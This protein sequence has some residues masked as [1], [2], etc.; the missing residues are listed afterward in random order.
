MKLELEKAFEEKL[1]AKLRAKPGKPFVD[2]FDTGLVLR[3]YSSGR[4]VAGVRY[5]A[6]GKQRFK[7]IRDVVKGVK[8]VTAA[9]KDAGDIRAKARLG[10]DQVAVDRA[11]RAAIAD[12]GMT[13][14]KLLPAFLAA[15]EANWRKSYRDTVELH[16]TDH[17][18]VLMFKPVKGVTQDDVADALKEVATKRGKVAAARA[19]ASLSTFYAWATHPDQ[20]HAR[21]S[22]VVRVRKRGGDGNGSRLPHLDAERA[23]GSMARAQG[24]E[25][26]LRP[27]RAAAD[28]H[29]AAPKCRDAPVD[30][31][32]PR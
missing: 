18:R 16:L 15:N 3:W 22:P 31:G 32:Q 7:V 14:V 4:M 6:N 11:T 8:W 1:G 26:G 30:R 5:T 21:S 28:P 29:G 9:R 10:I 19:R 13:I 27:H 24:R 17:L 20:R 12:R 23:H 25:R 2:V